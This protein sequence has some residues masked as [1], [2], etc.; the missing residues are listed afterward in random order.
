[1]PG[2]FICPEQMKRPGSPPGLPGGAKINAWTME[3]AKKLW[4]ELNHCT[5]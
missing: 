5:Y 4:G 2:Q 3:Q 1:M